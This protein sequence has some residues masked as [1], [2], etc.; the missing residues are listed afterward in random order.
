MGLRCFLIQMNG[1]FAD[2]DDQMIVIRSSESGL[3]KLF[4][5]QMHNNINLKLYTPSTT[6][7]SFLSESF[8]RQEVI[9]TFTTLTFHTEETGLTGAPTGRGL[10]EHWD[11]TS[12]HVKEE[13]KKGDD[14]R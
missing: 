11:Y 5:S 12:R 9:L 13:D 6:S 7:C 14:T 8:F 2:L 3:L 10:R 4:H 1:S